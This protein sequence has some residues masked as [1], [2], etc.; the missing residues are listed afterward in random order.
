MITKQT[1]PV[2]PCNR[3]SNLGGGFGGSSDFVSG[4][5]I[6]CICPAALR[7]PH[8]AL[9]HQPQG[10]V[11]ERRQVPTCPHCSFLWHEGEAGRC[12]RKAS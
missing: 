6:F 5:Y 4:S 7:G 2:E 11:R 1:C 10:Q 12:R 3:F 9:S 8:F